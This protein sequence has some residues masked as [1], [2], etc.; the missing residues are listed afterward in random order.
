MTRMNSVKHVLLAL[1]LGATAAA[2]GGT[3]TPTGKVYADI[4]SDMKALT[5]T[6]SGCHN[7][8]ATNKLKID[9]TAGKEQA[10]YDALFTNQLVIKGDA[11]N[12]PLIKVPSTG[13]GPTTSHV[14][15]LTGTKLTDWTDWVTAMAPFA[16]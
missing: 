1:G 8:T 7:A 12:S 16:N 2:C 9:T 11:A 3:T 6:Q 5:C 10:N 14:K 15:T 4:Q 13:M